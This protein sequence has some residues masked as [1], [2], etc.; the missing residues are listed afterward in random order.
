MALP[1]ELEKKILCGI[2]IDAILYVFS[3][4]NDAKELPMTQLT[5][6]SLRIRSVLK[7]RMQKAGLSYSDLAKEIGVS[8]PTIKRW[9]TK[10]DF[11]VEALDLILKKLNF[12]WQD[13]LL[14]IDGSEVKIRHSDE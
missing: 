11:P 10:Y 12:P 2:I 3:I 8:L 1:E 9:F 6:R 4:I 5:D 7:I 13:L 14:Q